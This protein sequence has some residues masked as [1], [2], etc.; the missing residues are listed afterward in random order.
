MVM[1]PDGYGACVKCC[2]NYT[3][4]HNFKEKKLHVGDT[5][6]KSVYFLS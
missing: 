6:P 4:N 3:L 5:D 2:E 1:G